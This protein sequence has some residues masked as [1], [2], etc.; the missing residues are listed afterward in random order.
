MRRW[1]KREGRGGRTGEDVA[2]VEVL[3]LVDRG[4][5]NAAGV[6]ALLLQGANGGG[7]SGALEKRVLKRGVECERELLVLGEEAL[8]EERN[9][10]QLL[11]FADFVGTAKNEKLVTGEMEEVTGSSRGQCTCPS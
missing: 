11:E 6:A 3:E 8:E 10:F 5:A 2:E 7:N 4:G 9:G 1:R